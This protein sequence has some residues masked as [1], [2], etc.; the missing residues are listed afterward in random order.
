[1]RNLYLTSLFVMLATLAVGCGS[2]ASMP[3]AS[4]PQEGIAPQ[5]MSLNWTVELS[6]SGG[7]AGLQRQLTVES[8]GAWRA[9][10]RKLGHKNGRLTTEQ[11]AKLNQTL[12]ALE[13]TPEAKSSR[14]FPSRCADCIETRINTI[15]SGKHYSI[16]LLS[17]TK[18]EQPYADLLSLLSPLLQAAFSKQ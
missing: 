12:S 2:N 4:H 1:M 9:S 6:K 11:L 7:I 13:N 18:I 14:S 17:G 8:N 15:L 16:T 10:D 3:D 5:G